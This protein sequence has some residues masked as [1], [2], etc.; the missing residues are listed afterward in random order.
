MLVR[1]S[2]DLGEDFCAWVCVISFAWWNYSLMSI[3]AGNT[4]KSMFKCLEN[5]HWE[6]N[7]LKDKS[8]PLD[9]P[10]LLS[11]R[12]AVCPQGQWEAGKKLSLAVLSVPSPAPL[13]VG[14]QCQAAEA[15][16]G[17]CVTAQQY[18]GRAVSPGRSVHS[19]Y[20]LT[21]LMHTLWYSSLYW[22]HMTN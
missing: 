20:T 13:K 9:P 11:L 16:S 8:L 7:I 4:W 10:G 15:T 21:L 12:I 17:F 2:P 5:F 18:S 3:S 19:R 1:M 6:T 22:H 14:S